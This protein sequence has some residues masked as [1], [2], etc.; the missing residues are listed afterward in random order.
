M[1]GDFDRRMTVATIHSQ[2]NVQLVV[3]PAARLLDRHPDITVPVRPTK[4]PPDSPKNG[5]HQRNTGK[6]THPG[7]RIGSPIEYL[8]HV[9]PF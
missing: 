8:G 3:E 9:A 6:D 4:Q 2:G 5:K 7:E 1:G